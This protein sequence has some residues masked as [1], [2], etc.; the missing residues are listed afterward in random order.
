MGDKPDTVPPIEHDTSVDLTQFT[1]SYASFN[2]IVNSLQRKYIDLKEEFSS[3]QK[4]LVETNQR[5]V[6]MT[7]SNL[8]TTEFLDSILNSMAAGVVAVDRNGR[9]TNFNPAAS[10]MLG[11]PG[12]EPLGQPYRDII[13]SGDPVDANALRAVESGRTVDS[14]EKNWE[15]IDGTRLI[16]SVSTATLTDRKG[17][18]L[19]AVEVF[20]DLTKIKKMELEITR[21]TTLAALGEMAAAVAHQVRNPL[22]G[23]L[24][25]GS[26]LRR[27]MDADDPRQKLVNRICDGVETLNKTVTTLLDFTHHEEVRRVNVDFSEYLNEAN[28]QFHRDHDE[29]V[30]QVKIINRV[31]QDATRGD[32]LISLDPVLFRQVLFNLFCN[33]C[34]VGRGQGSIV[35]TGRK[36]P[37]QVATS[38]YAGRL[39]LGLDETVFEVTVSDD[40]PGIP[41]S[42]LEELFAP[43][44]TTRE[45]GTGLGLAVAW[46]IMKGHGGDIAL[47]RA[48]EDGARFV[49]LLPTRIGT[50]TDHSEES[51]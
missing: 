10:V 44:F 11:I 39:L 7:A 47:D 5:L 32:N 2:R 19:G 34:E 26:L 51:N 13:P 49:L 4:E 6:D 8:A 21:L 24:G 1:D 20:H 42:A 15:L 25:Y 45:G 41:D 48:Y 27:D 12:R 23:I 14:I 30:G 29:L 16:V 17:N 3:Q 9:I 22:S 18:A 33:S 37:R 38:Q 28:R 31:N 40:G 46:K 36:L 50:D 43:F 35:V